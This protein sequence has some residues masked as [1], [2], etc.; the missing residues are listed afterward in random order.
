MAGP[1]ES[2]GAERRGAARFGLSSTV[3]VSLEGETLAATT[4]DISTGGMKLR[5]ESAQPTVG[6][7]L[8]LRLALPELEG[9]IEVEGVVR[10]VN[11]IAGNVCGVQFTTGLR[12][13]EVWAINRLNDS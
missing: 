11:R 3:E 2:M 9:P 5:F 1:G 7:R 6:A 8:G 13:R 12:A 10:W 4:E